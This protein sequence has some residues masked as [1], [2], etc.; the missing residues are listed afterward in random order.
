[1]YFFFFQVFSYI[2]NTNYELTFNKKKFNFFLPNL[3]LGLIPEYKNK[4]LFLN[5]PDSL[6]PSPLNFLYK[7]ITGT[8]NIIDKK[9]C[10]FSYLDFDAY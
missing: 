9:S 4:H 7:D 3:F 8:N 5:I 2:T 1:M 6:K 10:F